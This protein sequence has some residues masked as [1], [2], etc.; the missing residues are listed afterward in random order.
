MILQRSPCSSQ[1]LRTWS[2]RQ[3]AET[4]Q[5][6]ATDHIS[7]GHRLVLREDLAGQ[8]VKRSKNNIYLFKALYPKSPHWHLFSLTHLQIKNQMLTREERKRGGI[9]Q[10]TR[11]CGPSQAP[12]SFS[13]GIYANGLMHWEPSAS[14]RRIY[15]SFLKIP[16]DILNTS[17][18]IPSTNLQE[19]LKCRV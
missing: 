13:Q 5:R 17:D 11:K 8:S 7:N 12:Q 16:K 3:A 10:F 18:T 2:S 4:P 14:E 15:F 19:F 9:P 1:M 6:R